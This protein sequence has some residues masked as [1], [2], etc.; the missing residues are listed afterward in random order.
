LA[1]SITFCAI[2]LYLYILPS[3][4]R[5][6]FIYYCFLTRHFYIVN[7]RFEEVIG[8]VNN[9]AIILCSYCNLAFPSTMNTDSKL[10]DLA[11]SV[12]CYQQEITDVVP[13]TLQLLTES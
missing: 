1:P 4:M 3:G 8:Q 2:F 6:L 12:I 7:L 10:H 9:H 13:I 11:V 5:N